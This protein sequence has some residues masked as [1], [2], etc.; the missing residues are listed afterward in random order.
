MDWYLLIFLIC[1]AV[2]AGGVG[3]ALALLWQLNK[4]GGGVPEPLTPEPVS[5]IGRVFPEQPLKRGQR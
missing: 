1:M 2:A 3:F 5:R 4:P